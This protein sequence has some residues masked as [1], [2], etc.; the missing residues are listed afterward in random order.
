MQRTALVT[1]IELLGIANLDHQLSRQ[2]FF[3]SESK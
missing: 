1:A 2:G 3:E